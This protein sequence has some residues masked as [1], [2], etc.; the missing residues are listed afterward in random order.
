MICVHGQLTCLTCVT[1]LIDRMHIEGGMMGCVQV[2]LPESLAVRD[3][4]GQRRLDLDRSDEVLD[5]H[6]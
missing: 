3:S 1:P 6:A 2:K 5:S 4:Q